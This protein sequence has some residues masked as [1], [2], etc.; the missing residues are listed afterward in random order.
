MTHKHSMATQVANHWLWEARQASSATASSF[1]FT[2][3]A[4]ED[5]PPSLSMVSSSLYS[6]A[7]PS[8]L[9]ARTFTCCPISSSKAMSGKYPS[10][11]AFGLTNPRKGGPPEGGFTSIKAPK[12]A[13]LATSPVSQV[14]LLMPLISSRTSGV[15][16]CLLCGLPALPFLDFLL[17]SCTGSTPFG[18]IVKETL[19]PSPD[20]VTSSTLTLT[21]SP[22]SATK[23]GSSGSDPSRSLV[24]CANPETGALAPGTSTST[25]RPNRLTVATLP[26]NHSS[27]ETSFSFARASAS[28]DFLSTVSCNVFAAGFAFSTRPAISS[29]TE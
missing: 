3:T 27:S 19:P 25:K 20:K 28:A 4:S 21:S 6:F 24:M 9:K 26:V 5:A 22:T 23:I 15:I 18:S 10:T 2:S 14:L 16:S 13:I 8:K 11:M 17:G 12:P 29:P 7:S 1:S